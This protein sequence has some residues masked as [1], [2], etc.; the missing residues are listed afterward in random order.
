MKKRPSIAELEA[1]AAHWNATYPV[2]T[3]VTRYKLIEPLAEGTE[4]TT[5]SEAWVMSGHSVMVSV[6]GVSGGVV[7]ESVIPISPPAEAIE[8]DPKVRPTLRIWGKAS[9]KGRTAAAP[10]GSFTCRDYAPG[11]IARKTDWLEIITEEP[12]H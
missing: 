6:E 4:T 11:K 12:L 9:G 8:T 5:R 1:T 2:G 3:P 10:K 7:I